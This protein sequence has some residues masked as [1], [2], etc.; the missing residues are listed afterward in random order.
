MRSWSCAP[1]RG[2]VVGYTYVMWKP[3]VRVGPLR[4]RGPV[5]HLGGMSLDTPRLHADDDDVFFCFCFHDITES[6]A[7]STRK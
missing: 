1:L 7:P 5:H 2:N 3:K 6:V 4:G